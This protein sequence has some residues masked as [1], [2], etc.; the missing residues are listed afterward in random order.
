MAASLNSISVMQRLTAYIEYI[1]SNYQV[2]TE[3]ATEIQGEV[4]AEINRRYEA[5]QLAASMAGRKGG[6]VKSEAK[7]RA[8]REN[9][10]LGGRPK[11]K[12]YYSVDYSVW[13]ADSVKTAWFDNK[14]EAEHFAA[15]DYRDNP[16]AIEQ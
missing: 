7:T 9:G 3:E 1:R 6:K 8:S 13:G 5:I 15:H 16:V 14:E 10:K 12:T 11:M 4:I 2:N